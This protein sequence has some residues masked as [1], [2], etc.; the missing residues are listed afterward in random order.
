MLTDFNRPRGSTNS[1]I[2]PN[3]EGYN[4]ELGTIKEKIKNI[5]VED[6]I[7]PLIVSGRVVRLSVFYAA[8]LTDDDAFTAA[9]SA[10]KNSDGYVSKIIINDTNKVVKLTKQYKFRTNSSTRYNLNTYSGYNCGV[11]GEYLFSGSAQ[12]YF[13]WAYRPYVNVIIGGDG[14]DKGIDLTTP[15][16]SSLAVQFES[17]VTGGEV[18]IDGYGYNGYLFGTF[19]TKFLTSQGI[20][21]L[22]PSTINAY[23]C[24]GGVY[25]S[26]TN[27]TGEISSIWELDCTNGSVFNSI[28]DVVV[29]KY[30][31]SKLVVNNCTSLRFGYL[32]CGPATVKIFDSQ[33]IYIGHHLGILGDP[34]NATQ[35]ADTYC[36]EIVNSW[37][38]FGQTRLY[39]SNCGFKIGSASNV[40]FEQVE[41]KM[42]NQ[43]L[44]ITNNTSYTGTSNSVS[45]DVHVKQI[46][47]TDG[48]GQYGF[49]SKECIRI[50]DG[51]LGNLT[52]EDGR[53]QWN[54][55]GRTSNFAYGIYGGSLSTSN[56]KI[57]NVRF[58]GSYTNQPVYLPNT[59]CIVKIH[60]PGTEVNIAGSITTGDGRILR[61]SWG[62]STTETAYTGNPKKTF[63]WV[64]QITATAGNAIIRSD[65]KPVS[66]FSGAVG[67]FS[68]SFT[69]TKGQKLYYSLSSATVLDSFAELILG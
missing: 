53:I 18:H 17:V 20:K 54:V 11:V 67:T 34:A 58:L 10:A 59:D 52:V 39:G 49:S 69:A 61:V 15:T 66:Y 37:V 40:V 42:I 9:L 14:S 13:E 56:I 46:N 60:T 16:N 51:M 44:L 45:V 36:M 55:Y 21:G 41:G 50:E 22:Y 4:P 32:L 27:G 1:I 25:L 43:F 26:G 5:D 24:G 68:G 7:N 63:Y 48:N 23:R 19:G 8:G 62:L 2:D 64:V 38:R 33:G 65:T 29:S 12:F 6:I 35:T 57:D 3:W 31:G 28:Y 47:V 30:E